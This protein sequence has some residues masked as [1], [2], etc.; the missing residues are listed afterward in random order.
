[1]PKF[2][3]LLAAL[4]LLFGL[5]LSLT[6]CSE[7]DEET[8]AT[9]VGWA[10]RNEAYFLEKMRTAKSAI[11]QAKATYGDDWEAHTTW[12]TFRTYTLPTNYTG[13]T[14]TDSIAVQIV[15]AGNGTTY[16]PFYTDS[17][18]IN[19]L[20]RYIPN[21]YAKEGSV[22]RTSG[23]VFSYTGLSSDSASVFSPEFSRPTLYLVSNTVEG[24]TTALMQMHVGDMW[25]VYIPHQLGY[26]TSSST[27][28]GSSTLVYDIELKG[29]YR[30]GTTPGSWN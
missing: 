15:R 18:R 14:T 11:A 6:A 26:G 25:R 12:R 5:A 4:T 9:L 20:G 13:A 7:T 16:Q 28:R 23:E 1:M 21:V 27:P 24:F 10:E 22:A 3:P 17:V 2:K 30:K 29:I 19:L 8:D